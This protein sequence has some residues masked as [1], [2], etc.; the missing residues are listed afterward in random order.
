MP[1]DNSNDIEINVKL[2]ARDARSELSQLKNE[3]QGFTDS[4]DDTSFSLSS[5]TKGI[6]L[7]TAAVATATGAFIGLKSVVD[8]GDKFSDIQEGFENAAT[9]A[10]ILSDVLLNNL[11]AAT[12]GAVTNLELMATAS[13]ALQLGIAADQLDDLALAAQRFADKTGGDAVQSLN[14]L[15][16]A[17]NTGRE[18]QLRLFGTVQDGVLILDKFTTAQGSAESATRSASDIIASMA[19]TIENTLG[20]VAAFINDLT[21]LKLALAGAEEVLQDFIR[22]LGVL[23]EALASVVPSVSGLMEAFS[24]TPFIG[25]FLKQLAPTVAELEEAS[26]VAAELT[27]WMNKVRTTSSGTSES[28][29]ILGKSA[30][31]TSE[32]SSKL[33]T[34]L[35]KTNSQLSKL[36]KEAK[37]AAASLQTIK[38]PATLGGDDPAID[39][40]FKPQSFDLGSQIADELKVQFDGIADETASV[41]GDSLITAFQT[42]L[43]LLATAISGGQIDTG[44]LVS[45]LS[46]TVGTI[47]GAS[48]GGPAGAQIGQIAGSF[49][50]TVVNGLIEHFNSDTPGTTARKAADK[51]FADVFDANR[52]AIVVGDQLKQV[53]D[54]VFKGDTP[55]GGNA[56]FASGGFDDFL[57]TLPANVQAGLK[58]VGAAF[59]ELLGIGEDV[60]GQLAAVIANNIGGEL[61]N[62]QLLVEATGKSFDELHNAVVEAFLDGKLSIEEAQIALEGL[63]QVSQ[64]GIP[65]AI[66]DIAQAFRN[67]QAAASSGKGS[68][69]LVDAIRDIGVEAQE[70]GVRDLPTLANRLVQVF[71][72]SAQQVANFFQAMKATG[73]NSL[74]ELANAGTEVAIALASNL[75]AITEG[76]DPTATPVIPATTST[77][78]GGSG[79]GRSTSGTKQKTKAQQEAE[80]KKKQQEQERKRLIQEALKLAQASESY[81]QILDNLTKGVLS[82]E[83]ASDNLN[84][85]YASTHKLLTDLKVAQDKYN[86]ALQK[87]NATSDQAKKVQELQAALDALTEK[88]QKAVKTINLDFLK[89]FSDNLNIIGLAANEL[90]VSFEDTQDKIVAAFKAGKLSIAEANAELLKAQDLLSAGIPGAS[91]AT[92]EAFDNL[93]KGG[94]KGGAFSIDAFKDIF[95]EAQEKFLKGLSPARSQQFKDLTND[96]EGLKQAL[97]DALSGGPQSGESRSD[98]D[99]RVESLTKRFQGAKKALDDFYET[100]PKIGLEDLR[101]ILLQDIDPNLVQTFFQGLSDSGINTFD[102][103]ANASDSVVL[104]I[105]NRLGELSFPFQE[106]SN[107]IQRVNDQLAAITQDKDV[108]IRFNVSTGFADET[109]ANIFGL[110]YGNTTGINSSVEITT[111]GLS[112]SERVEFDRLSSIRQKKGK[113]ALTKDQRARFD[114]LRRK[115]A[116]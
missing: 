89:E 41:I 75:Q 22:G 54:L 25:G 106:T 23:K 24:N 95:A 65:G 111:G 5:F 45:N 47:I 40:L 17:V 1:F 4:V 85:L 93:L 61:N 64:A 91:G 27:G 59:E 69:A 60:A 10:G 26:K 9:Q 88:A 56:D 38:T 32:S 55:F 53:T 109:T 46:S 62:L 100:M 39:D 21:L 43:D 34:N 44:Q 13:K 8:F 29:K 70:V 105:L 58:G 87:G 113:G 92:K 107:E 35:Q 84:K 42:G 30:D 16:Q 11:S 57:T 14:Q 90:G 81:R 102:D 82:Q 51:F 116:A 36:S 98:F 94:V 3:T 101:T 66:G 49:V 73:I 6:G 72:F 18:A 96:F 12:K 52:L 2:D 71:G 67:L 15:I 7:V 31:S 115:A 112:S 68:R 37:D 104:G 80:A 63:Q 20:S 50:G 99:A 108:S 76:K 79:I 114:A 74:Q 78:T 110:I 48:F 33:S 83:A 19:A 86:A 28:V 97:N 103:L 77:P